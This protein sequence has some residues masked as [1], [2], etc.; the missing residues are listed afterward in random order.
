M[1]IYFSISGAIEPQFYAE[2]LKR[3][4]L[5]ANL[6]PFQLDSSKWNNMKQL[7]TNIFK[8]K[9]QE[10]W[11]QIFY[12]SDACV[13]PVY[14]LNYKIPEPTPKLL[15]TSGKLINNI[16]Y[17]LKPGEHS[18]E[19]LKEYGYSENEIKEFSIKN[20]VDGLNYS[21]SLL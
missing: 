1:I 19:I 13:T 5:D 3:L 15:R 20:I 11:T 16:K 4:N 18:R 17:F 8:T 14:E 10:E 21:K 9:T 6:L 2:L 7:F 12:K